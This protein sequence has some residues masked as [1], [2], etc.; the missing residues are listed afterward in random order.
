MPDEVTQLPLF[1][2]EPSVSS[3]VHHIMYV[4]PTLQE[5]DRYAHSVCRELAARGIAPPS[6]TDTLRGFAAFIR[7]VVTATT[8]HR[9]RLQ[10]GAKLT[11]T[12]ENTT[13]LNTK[14]DNQDDTQ[15]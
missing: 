3:S 13:Y 1:P 15:T 7:A 2:D 11:S 5:I 4:S 8:H 14:G 9:N 12:Q 6:D 10:N